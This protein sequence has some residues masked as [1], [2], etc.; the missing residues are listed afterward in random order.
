MLV[1]SLPQPFAFAA[2]A[3]A[4][5]VA[6]LYYKTD[7]RGQ[8]LLHAPRLTVPKDRHAP[9]D[10]IMDWRKVVSGWHETWQTDPPYTASYL[11][12]NELSEGILGMVEIVDCV[13]EHQSA[14]MPKTGWGLV[15]RDARPLPFTKCPGIAGIWECQPSVLRALGVA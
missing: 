10:F 11:R 12:M 3:F 8:V 7:V 15:L 2:I 1:L 14:W 9:A 5:D 6:P 4:M 13:K